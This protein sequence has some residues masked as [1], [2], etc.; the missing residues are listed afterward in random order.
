MPY[1][2]VSRTQGLLRVQWVGSLRVL[3]VRI[4]W[5]VK[6]PASSTVKRM[7]EA[8]A[9]NEQISMRAAGSEPGRRR[10]SKATPANQVHTVHTVLGESSSSEEH[11]RCAC[12]CGLCGVP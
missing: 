8:R 3:G 1:C 2:G 10:T 7:A 12:A 4:A 9:G 6:R 11:G 5:H